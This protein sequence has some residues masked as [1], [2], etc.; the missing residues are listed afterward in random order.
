MSSPRTAR[1]KV[2]GEW[3]GGLGMERSWIWRKGRRVQRG[4]WMLWG[5]AELKG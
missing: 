1:H 3:G 2:L 5:A 4:V